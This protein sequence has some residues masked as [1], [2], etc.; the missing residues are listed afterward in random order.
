MRL[1]FH[2]NQLCLRGTSVAMFDY[3]F[4]NE[5]I[6][7]NESFIVYDSKSRFN[8]SRGISKFA[9]AF[10]NRVFAY[11]NR[12]E[13]NSICDRLNIDSCYMIK[14]GENDGLLTNR[15]NIVHVVFQAHQPHGDVYAYVS[16]WLSNKMTGGKIP[17]VPHMVHLPKPT[18]TARKQLGIPSDAVVFGRYGGMDQFDIPFVKEAVIEYANENPD[19]W[20]MFMNTIPFAN[21]PR[22]LFIEG[23]SDLQ[24]KSNF[25][26]SCDAMIHG[27]SMGESFGL[28][29]CEFLYGNK[30]VLA[31]NGGNDQ[32]HIDI[33]RDE[34][35]L[36][37]DK[38][39]LLK[40][41][42]WIC[43]L[44]PK[45]YRHIVEKF[46]PSVVMEKFKKVFLE[47]R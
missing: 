31:W 35:M 1:L 21:H 4:F 24:L 46:K 23:T 30:P 18:G 8:D 9:N 2:N 36:Y 33:L 3:A 11:E 42:D 28:A 7:G 27:R 38:T 47:A 5:S 19:C 44:E 34:D 20:F 40:K 37:S 15:K 41:M 25:I 39:D 26:E 16:E 43:N 45:T 32:H 17:Y 10:P 12:S 29:I 6:L 13:I 14:G 22:I